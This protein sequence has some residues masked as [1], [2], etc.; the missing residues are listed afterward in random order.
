MNTT[1]KINYKELID[2]VKKTQNPFSREIYISKIKEEFGN[3]FTVFYDMG[4]GIAITVRSFI[5]SKDLLLTEE[6]EVPGA[7][8]IFNL[9]S[10]I[11]FIYKDKK[12]HI[13]KKEHFFIELASDKFYCEIPLKK[14]ES[15]VSIFIGIKEELF[16]ELANTI[17]DIQGYMKQAFKQGYY[18]L[19]DSQIDTLQSELFKDFKNKEYFQDILKSIYLESKTTDLLQHTIQKVAKN[20]N[21][22]SSIN[23]NKSRILSLERAKEI[24]MKEYSSKLSIKSIAYK[25]A[26]NECYLKKDFKEYFGMTILE[27]LQKRR[28]EMAKQLLK[29]NFSVKEV[30]LKIGYKNA[31]HFSKLFIDYFNISPSIYRKQFNTQ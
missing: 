5:P 27:M 10:E 15:F 12:E 31:S 6:C 19:N 24:I 1:T 26:I 4:N 16:L 29:E 25:S 11:K 20:L 21:N 9:A 2:I 30:T 7:S 14:N 23:Y 13:L 18:V 17:T 3:G 22:F 28:L 8:L